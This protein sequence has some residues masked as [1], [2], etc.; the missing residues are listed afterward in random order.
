MVQIKHAVIYEKVIDF[1]M[2]PT[3]LIIRKLNHNTGDKH[4][5]KL[6]E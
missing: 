1:F 3:A 4:L 6:N 2:Q 5:D